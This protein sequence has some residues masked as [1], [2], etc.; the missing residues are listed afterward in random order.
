M[1]ARQPFIDI[2]V[3]LRLNFE[4]NKLLK[5]TLAHWSLRQA[6]RVGAAFPQQRLEQR[7]SANVT[8]LDYTVPD[9]PD[10]EG[11]AIAMGADLHANDTLAKG[12][13]QH[14]AIG[15]VTAEIGH[16]RCIVAVAAINLCQGIDEITAVEPLRQFDQFLKRLAQK[17]TAWPREFGDNNPLRRHVKWLP[18]AFEPAAPPLMSKLRWGILSTGR[19]AGVF[20]GLNGFLKT[21]PKIFAR[22]VPHAGTLS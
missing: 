4:I 6:D 2:P 21:I 3:L 15:C 10:L 1:L 12:I 18:I 16:D 11:R 5:R 14:L 22:Y 17:V 19:I 9:A 8:N 7:C 13:V 20:A